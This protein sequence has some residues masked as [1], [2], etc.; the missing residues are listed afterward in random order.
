M[1]LFV[2]TLNIPFLLYRLKKK[3]N[4]ETHY[5]KICRLSCGYVTMFLI[6]KKLRIYTRITD[7]KIPGQQNKRDF[8]IG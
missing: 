7:L 1:I 3:G 4:I 5:T 6:T 8:I 2:G